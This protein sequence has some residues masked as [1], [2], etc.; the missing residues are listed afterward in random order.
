M[1]VGDRARRADRTVHLVWPDVVAIQRLAGPGRRH[2]A[3]I[4]QFAP[5][6]GIGAQRGFGVSERRHRRHGFPLHPQLA[7]GQHR[8]LFALGH[9]A[10]EVALH[11]HIDQ[12]RHIAHRFAVD[13]EQAVADEIAAVAASVRRPHH[14]PM[15]HAGDAHVVDEGQHAACLGGDIDA[16]SRAADDAVGRHRLDRHVVGQRQ[17]HVLALHQRAIADG[18]V[19]P[20]HAELAILRFELA[21]RHAQLLCG[22]RQQPCACLRRG[23]A[24]RDGG[25]LDRC[26]GDGRA[27]VGRGLG[28]AEH[29]AHLR[30]RHVEFFRHDLRQRRADAGAQVDVAIEGQHLATVAHGDEDVRQRRHVVRRRAGLAGRG[31]RRRLR[32]ARDQQHAGCLQ[33]C[34]PQRAGGGGIGLCH[35][36]QGRC[37]HRLPIS[38]NGG[39]VILPA[40]GVRATQSS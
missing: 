3:V 21:G 6:R 33:Q 7:R 24:Q 8:I 1:P 12:A 39:A 10:D 25:N 17:R 9:H 40:N 4:Q 5:R 37:R 32:R 30:Q 14:A 31:T 28:M 27:L 22:A 11:H 16:A 35:G 18:G 19:G 13:R 20:E 15:Q 23:T 36:L 29:H 34:Q 2:L 38:F 26:A